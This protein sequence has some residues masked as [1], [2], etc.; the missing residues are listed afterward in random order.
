MYDILPIILYYSCLGICIDYTRY[1]LQA[2]LKI[3]VLNHNTP[4]YNIYINRNE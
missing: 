2:G 4:D 3:H 1:S